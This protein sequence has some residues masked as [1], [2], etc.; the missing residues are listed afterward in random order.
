[1]MKRSALF[2]ALLLV[3]TLALTACT[4]PFSDENT[5]TTET[6][7]A[8]NGD[9]GAS[10]SGTGDNDFVIVPD[11]DLDATGIWFSNAANAAIL[12]EAKS[13]VAKFYSCSAGYYEY[14]AVQ[15]ATYLLDD[16]SLTMT[17][18]DATYEFTYDADTDILTLVTESGS[19]AYVRQEKLPTEH[20]TYKFPKYE[21]IDTS[22]ILTLPD[23]QSIDVWEDVVA[24]ARVEIFSQHFSDGL[25]QPATITDRAAVYGDLVVI[26][27]VGKKDGV[28]FSGGTATN[29]ELQIIG[30]SG[31]IPGFVDGIIGHSAGESFEVH[32]TFPD[33]YSAAPELAGQPVV[34]EMTLHTIYQLELSEG[35]FA[36]H[37]TEYES[38][39]D[40]VIGL[41]SENAGTAVLSEI[42]SSTELIGELPEE[43]YMYF[44]QINLDYKHYTYD[45]YGLLH[46]DDTCWVCKSYAASYLQ[47]SKNYALSY[48]ICYQ[49]AAEQGLNW[50]EEE[51]NAKFESYVEKLMENDRYTEEEAR[52]YVTNNQLE[53]LRAE[54]TVDMVTAYLGGLQQ[55]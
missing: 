23:Y 25:R 20:L 9:Q 27:Y 12:F 35:Q 6:T 37:T 24:Q 32:V 4:F 46:I 33:T 50:T 14:Y 11:A 48:L 41:A 53:P 51:Y 8:Q 38:Y 49:I 7:A 26:D 15:D 19:T 55:K 40:W 44:Y 21:E 30:N 13:H 22:T 2:L 43:S 16:T 3:G 1:M 5:Q 18:D 45:Y 10:N 34:F 39:E 54:L 28:A 31:Y 42:F 17:L 29:V 47:Q 52:L 36:E